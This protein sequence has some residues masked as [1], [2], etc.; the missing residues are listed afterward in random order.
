LFC[1]NPIEVT[2]FNFTSVG[3]LKKQVEINLIS[4]GDLSISMKLSY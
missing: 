1:G 3:L 4:Q 2:K